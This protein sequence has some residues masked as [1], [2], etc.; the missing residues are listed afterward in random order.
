MS[1][2]QLRDVFPPKWEVCKD[3]TMCPSEDGPSRTA[4]TCSS[5]SSRRR[6][7]KIC[8]TREC[9]AMWSGPCISIQR[10]S[11]TSSAELAHPDTCAMQAV[12]S[13]QCTLSPASRDCLTGVK[14]WEPLP[15]APGK[16]RRST[17]RC[18]RLPTYIAKAPK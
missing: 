1:G 17:R 15:D 14:A 16:R 3:S 12:S 18:I 8:F 4:D 13:P 11:T 10:T 2:F 9:L 6:C 7:L 5:K